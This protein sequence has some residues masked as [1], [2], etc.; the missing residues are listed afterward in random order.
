MLLYKS[1]TKKARILF[2]VRDY[3][4]ISLLCNDQKL[5]INILAKRVQ[6]IITKC[7][8]P[9]KTDFIPR[10]QGANNIRRTLNIMSC[11]KRKSQISILISLDAHKAF[12]QV[13]WHFS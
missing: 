13:N 3:R 9:D 10:T 11:A 5:L 2:S 7:I 4:P 12:D 8:N 6:N 1:F